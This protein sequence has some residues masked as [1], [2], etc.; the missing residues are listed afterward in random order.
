MDSLSFNKTKNTDNNLQVSFT[1]QKSVI[2]ETG[3]QK[4][5]FFAPPYN[6]AVKDG[7]KTK[8]YAL[9]LEIVPLKYETGKNGNPTGN[10]VAGGKPEIILNSIPL[11]KY[12]SFDIDANDETLPKSDL[13]GYRFAVIDEDKLKKTKNLEQ[14]KT[15]EYILDSGI[16]AGSKKDGEFSYFSKKQGFV[17]KTG[18]MYHIFPDS[19]NTKNTEDFVRNH[20]NKAGGNIR[21][22]IDKLKEPNSELEPYEMIISTPLFGADDISSHGYWTMNPYQITSVKGNL[23]DFRELQN[24]MFDTGKSYVADGAFTSFSMESPQMQQFFKWGKNSLTYNWVKFD[25][26][27]APNGKVPVGVL[28]DTIISGAKEGSAAQKK[29]QTLKENIGFKVINPKFVE[30][31]GKSKL[32]LTPDEIDA[33]KSGESKSA[34]FNVVP[35]PHYDPMKPTYIQ[36]LDKRFASEKQMTDT[37]NLITKYS[38]QTTKNRYD[39]ADHNDSLYNFYFKVDPNDNR[40]KTKGSTLA[41]LDEVGYV[42]KDGSKRKGYDSYFEMDHYTI[43]T[44]GQAGGANNWDGNVDLFKANISNPTNTPEN[45]IGNKQ[46]RSYY[47]NLASY[48]TKLTNDTL[49]EHIAKNVANDSDKAFSRI[50]KSYNI[51]K[52]ELED[53]QDEVINSKEFKANF[54]EKITGM[55]TGSVLQHAVVDFPLESVEFAPDLSAVLLSDRITPRPL[56]VDSDE[57]LSKT[58]LLKSMP[59]TVQELYNGPMQDYFVTVLRQLDKKFASKGKE[60]I[61]S[62]SNTDKLTDYGKAIVNM[63]SVDV[64]KYGTVMALFPDTDVNFEDGKIKYDKNL[65]YK[66]VQSL[67]IK[68]PSPEDEADAVLH[69]LKSGFRKLEGADNSKLVNSLYS[70]FKNVKLDDIKT[71]KAIIDK[72]GAGLNWRFDA[73]KDV[74]DLDKRRE[75]DPHTTFEKCWDDVNDFWGSF[76]QNIR[77]ENKAAYV[78]AEVTDL[79]AFSRWQAS[80]INNKAEKAIK[81][82]NKMGEEAQKKTL[83]EFFQN[84]ANLVLQ[85]PKAGDKWKL[86]QASDAVKDVMA[87]KTTKLDKKTFE[88][89][90]KLYTDDSLMKDIF[91]SKDYGKYIDPDTAERIFYEKT[92]ATTGSNYSTF[93]GLYP[94]LFGQNFENGS[95]NWGFKPWE[96]EVEKKTGGRLYNMG[97]F[98]ESIRGFFRTAMPS[99]INGSH[100][101]VNNHDKPRPFHC[102]ALDMDLF[103]G[104]LKTDEAKAVAKKVTGSENYDKMS[105]MAVAVG[106]KYLTIFKNSIDKLNYDSNSGVKVTDEDKKLI[107]QA[108]SDLVQGKFLGAPADMTT[109]RAFGFSPFDITMKEVIQQ[110]RYIAKK[111]NKD[112]SLG[113]LKATDTYLSSKEQILFDKTFSELAPDM[114]KLA[115]L[116]KTMAFTVGVPTIFAGDEMAHSGYETPTKNAELA[117]RNIVHHEWL[118]DENKPFVKENYQKIIA[119]LGAHKKPELAALADGKPL[120]VPQGDNNHTALF[121]YNENGSNVLVVYSNKRMDTQENYQKEIDNILNSSMSD[122]EKGAKIKAIATKRAMSHLNDETDTVKSINL[123]YT[124]ALHG[125]AGVNS[126]ARNGDK[127]KKLVYDPKTGKYTDDGRTYKVENGKLVREGM[128]T[129]SGKSNPQIELDDVVNVF[130]KV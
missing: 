68:A 130:Y 35:N 100:I 95:V 120:V 16:S 65:K 1:G 73:A 66:G 36:F 104:N 46:V 94:E 8:K 62:A 117:V 128:Q 60:R 44:K 102:V 84:D 38:K 39:V 69:K 92:G 72:T 28:P 34:G 47:Y 103:L 78:I 116:I 17:N 5:R 2:L 99:F 20:F 85:N 89:L 126:V 121:K 19:Y 129:Q 45:V 63:I 118:K 109:S 21:G 110:A 113:D 82:F 12:G 101:F 75:Q 108:I 122:D 22:I 49:M 56:S 48:W 23:D 105:S 67:G 31:D 91:W 93:F 106:D 11:L 24:T 18:P 71:A 88:E 123:Q 124:D 37:K 29:A 9:A 13:V 32:T 70:R 40:F 87:G 81:D 74:A 41:L 76:I 42:S 61:F 111:Q 14:A 15:G 53:I 80:S 58:E 119:A 90:K 4:Y 114:D 57:T 3:A 77:K 97:E 112:W 79:W 125:N 43:T 25:K 83:L 6:N 26:T 33:L 50:S 55:S 115:A 27:D 96:S 10:V 107:K 54:K 98:Q 86:E 127:F 59:K 64:M 30:A 51:D 52:F 7:D